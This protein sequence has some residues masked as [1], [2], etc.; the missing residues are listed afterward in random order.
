MPTLITREELAA[1]IKA[2]KVEVLDVRGRSAYKRAHIPGA[3]HVSEDGMTDWAPDIKRPLAI[4]SSG[5]EDDRSSKA[6]ARLDGEGFENVLL[7]AEGFRDWV[8]HRL[9]CEPPV[10]SYACTVCSF[11]YYPS[12]GYPKAGAPP[13][14]LFEDLPENW[15]CPWCGAPKSKFEPQGPDENQ[16]A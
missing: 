7:Y 6:A 13:G 4:Y 2:G 12:R 11:G 14:T 9:P 5:P 10:L 3:R 16:H 8:A 15:R 1:A